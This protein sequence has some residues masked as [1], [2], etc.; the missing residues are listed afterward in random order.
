MS[1]NAVTPFGSAPKMVD[2]DPPGPGDAGYDDYRKTGKL[3]EAPPEEEAKPEPQSEEIAAPPLPEGEAATPEPSVTRADSEPAPTQRKRLNADERKKQLNA[4]IRELTKIAAELREQ[5][6]RVPELSRPEPAKA[7]ATQSKPEPQPTDVD[8]KGKPLYATWGDYEKAAR[9]WVKDEA[10]REAL[11]QF[12]ETQTK[13]Q[14]EQSERIVAQ[15]WQSEV[16]KAR[17]KHDNFDEVALNPTLP[18]VKG[19]VIDSFILESEHGAEIAYELGSNPEEITRLTGLA[20]NRQFVRVG[21]GLLPVAQLREL[22]KLEAEL[23]APVQPAKPAIPKPPARTVTKAPPPPTQVSGTPS[24]TVDEL[25]EAVKSG[26]QDTYNRVAN[27]RA[28]A[29][30]KTRR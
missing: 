26:D 4:E 7:T 2:F 8:D 21:Q 12:N 15:K 11:H 30:R 18:I 14:Q 24:K 19:G 6:T 10:I 23:G 29:S 9:Q 5:G 20:Y 27:E 13:A 16:L 3:P 25:A 28:L 17:Q 22:L 1:S